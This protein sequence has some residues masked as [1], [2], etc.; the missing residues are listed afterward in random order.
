MFYE[1]AID[2]CESYHQWLF[3]THNL[4]ELQTRFGGVLALAGLS[5]PRGLLDIVGHSADDDGVLS[6]FIAANCEPRDDQGWLDHCERSYDH[7][8][9]PEP[10]VRDLNGGM[11]TFPG[12]GVGARG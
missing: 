5:V 4:D 12:N 9:P 11:V 8:P 10:T 7:E 1:D 3:L 2:D 6:V